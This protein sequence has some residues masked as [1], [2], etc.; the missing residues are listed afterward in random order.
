MRF[1]RARRSLNRALASACHGQ[2]AMRIVDDSVV[3]A[4]H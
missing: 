4:A 2:P 3:R 1:A